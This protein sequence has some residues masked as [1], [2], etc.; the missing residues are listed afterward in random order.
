MDKYITL[1]AQVLELLDQ[2]F[3]EN[4]PLHGRQHTLKSLDLVEEYID[5]MKL[6]KYEAQMLRLAVLMKDVGAIK[7]SAGETSGL[8]MAKQL[9]DKAGFTFVQT[10][11]VCNLVK[12]ANAKQR[13]MNLLERII[14]DIDH[15]YLSSPNYEEAS[16][17]LYQEL[18]ENSMVSSRE[19]WNTWQLNLLENH[20]FHTSYGREKHQ[21]ERSMQIEALKRSISTQMN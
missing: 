7:V 12:A 20:R 21:G 19:E 16:E 6:G 5:S 15:A 4:S 3:P 10:K 11:V 14:S 8:D 2:K 1:Q 17:M 9:M 13:P 18:L